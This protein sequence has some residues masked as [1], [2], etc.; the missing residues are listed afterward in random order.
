MD[1]YTQTHMFTL[2]VC[3]YT[4]STLATLH[5]IANKGAHPWERVTLSP[6]SHELSI[7]LWSGVGTPQNFPLCTLTHPLYCYCS[8]LVFSAFLGETVSQQTSWYLVTPPSFPWCSLRYRCRSCYVDVP[9]GAV[10]QHLMNSALCPVEV[11]C[12]VL[13]LL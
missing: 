12:D 11:F 5:C 2:V 3:V 8:C 13:Y 6:S 1:V 9:F 7:V 10:L 4:V